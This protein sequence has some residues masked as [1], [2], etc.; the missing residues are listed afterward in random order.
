MSQWMVKLNG[1]IEDVLTYI[2]HSFFTKSA[3]VTT[4]SQS[5]CM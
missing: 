1:T 3:R 4:T 5:I 2:K